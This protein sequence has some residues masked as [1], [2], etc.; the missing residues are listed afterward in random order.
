MCIQHT[1][2]CRQVQKIIETDITLATQLAESDRA[3]DGKLA[4]SANNIAA[5]Q[6][7]MEALKV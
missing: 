4:S 6:K 7:E 1:W 3:T 5:C 2:L